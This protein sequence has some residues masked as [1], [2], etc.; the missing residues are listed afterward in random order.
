M[1]QSFELLHSRVTQKVR[2][3]ADQSQVFDGSGLSG[4]QGFEETLQLLP[5]KVSAIATFVE[6]VDRQ[7]FEHCFVIDLA[8]G[9][10]K[11]QA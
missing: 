11:I 7:R 4:N 2:P 6:C 1:F 10:E 9:L 3:G 8:T 5:R